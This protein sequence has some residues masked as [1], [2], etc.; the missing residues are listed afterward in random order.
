MKP[1]RRK[2]CIDWVE[3]CI[4]QLTP[5][6]QPMSNHGG[7]QLDLMVCGVDGDKNKKS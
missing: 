5:R 2:V 7:S 4:N 1:N 3:F 6:S